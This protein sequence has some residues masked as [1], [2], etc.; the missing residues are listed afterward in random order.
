MWADFEIK[1]KA[2][3]RGMLKMNVEGMSACLLELNPQVSLLVVTCHKEKEKS[4]GYQKTG[5]QCYW[6]CAL[7]VA[8]KN[9]TKSSDSNICV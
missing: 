2:K 5:H 9:D 1:T 7:R 3:L 4:T 8:R 6:E